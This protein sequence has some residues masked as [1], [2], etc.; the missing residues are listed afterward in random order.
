MRGAKGRTITILDL[1]T[2][3]IGIRSGAQH[4]LSQQQQLLLLLL[5]VPHNGPSLRQRSSITVHA[6][7]PSCISLPSMALNYSKVKIKT[8]F[9]KLP[10]TH[11]SQEMA[12]LDSTI[13]VLT[14]YVHREAMILIIVMVLDFDWL[15]VC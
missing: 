8:N 5:V 3:P 15:N 13:S 7:F 2:L 9:G 12:I 6:T 14:V 10:L 4:D 1:L 11:N